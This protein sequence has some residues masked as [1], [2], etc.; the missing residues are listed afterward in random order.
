MMRLLFVV[1]ALVAS[2]SFALESCPV[3]LDGKTDG[4]FDLQTQFSLDTLSAN[5]VFDQDVIRYEWSVISE[6]Q[7]TPDI[8]QQT[9][10]ST[11]GF[12]GVP[13]T[14]PWTDAKKLTSVS[15]SKLDLAPRQTYYVVLRTILR[16]GSLAFSNSNGMIVLPSVLM[17]SEKVSERSVHQEGREALGSTNSRAERNILIEDFEDCP[18]DNANRCR[19]SQVSVADILNDLYGPAV[20]VTVP[21]FATPVPPLV[22]DG[23]STTSDDDDGPWIAGIVI[24]A[25]FLLALLLL[26]LALL[27][28]LF[29]RGEGEDPFNTSVYSKEVDDVDADNGTRTQR[30]TAAEQRVEFPDIDPHSRLSTA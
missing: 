2:V 14:L 5:W 30:T 22:P 21:I 19:Q 23:S 20:F 7:A 29:V 1:L 17:T 16:D 6:N 13:D 4:R 10:R 15:A 3:V 8:H 26:I 28:C 18:I 11:Q 12:F 27:A 25:L 24:G 9:C